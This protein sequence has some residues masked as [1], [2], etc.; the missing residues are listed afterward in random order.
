MQNPVYIETEKLSIG[1]FVVLELSWLKHP[2]T[3]S[4]F[5]VQ[6]E[7]QLATLR[8]LGLK[9]IRIDPLRG[10]VVIASDKAPAPE[11]GRP[12][13]PA[14]ESPVS[15][16]KAARIEQNREL[17]S[18][19]SHAEK[20]A[21]RAAVQVRQTTRQFHSDPPMAIAGANELISSI[22]ESLLGNSEVMVH[23]LNDKVAGEEVYYHALNVSMLALILG[24]AMGFDAATLQLIGIAA[25]FHDIG[26][27][28]IPSRILLKTEPLTHPEE[29]LIRQ[30]CET[31]ARMAARGGL[32]E[33]A[34]Q[35]ILQHHENLD[36]SGY[37]SGLAGESIGRLARVVSIANYYDTLCNP[38]NITLAVTPYEALSNM[39]AKRKSWFDAGMLGRLVHVLGVYPP[40]SIVRLSSGATGMVISVNSARP[41]QPQVLVYDASV[42]KAEAIILDLEKTPE[43]SISKALRPNTLAPSV[44]EYLSPRKRTT[45][46][47]GADSRPA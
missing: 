30:H 7:E 40:G 24:K 9:Q 16:E 3:F 34:V 39:F 28:D 46:Y 18:S 36:G 26:K 19:I 37:P 32:P 5:V 42:P 44:Y 41:L 17:R 21:A 13:A 14:G 4:S 27:E 11:V 15:L 1:M 2:F 10:K 38:P 31:G 29:T 22:A 8:G 33:A 23:L 25:V 47:F 43:I 35:A 6:T 12:A 20:Q 45:Y